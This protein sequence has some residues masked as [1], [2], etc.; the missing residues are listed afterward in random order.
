MPAPADGAASTEAKVVVPAVVGQSAPSTGGRGF[1]VDKHGFLGSGHF[2]EVYRGRNALT[3]EPVAIKLEHR[4]RTIAYREWEV[5]MRMQRQGCPAVYYT[6]H[7]GR[8][9]VCVMQLLGLTLQRALESRPTRRFTWPQVSLIGL[10]CLALL[11]RLH[12]HGYIH[13]DVK[14]ENFLL[15]HRPAKSTSSVTHSSA[16]AAA[17]GNDEVVV[18]ESPLAPMAVGEAAPMAGGDYLDGALVGQELQPAPP[19]RPS[20]S[21]SA[22]STP[23]RIDLNVPLYM[24]DMGL[25]SRWR[26][27]DE[28][29]R[30]IPYGQRIDH[31]S[32]T[33]RYASLNAHLGRFLTRRDDL[34]SLGY[35]LIYLLRGQLPWQG[36]MGDDKN[37]QVCEC[38]G[39]LL[40]S[41][42]CR[43]V[44]DE[45]RYFLAYVRQLS[46]AE[47][48]DYEYM[49]RVLDHKQ[50]ISW[51][52]THLRLAAEGV[53]L[54]PPYRQ[55]Q[56]ITR[57]A[58]GVEG[59]DESERIPPASSLTVTRTVDD[60]VDVNSASIS[61]TT[62]KRKGV[63]DAHAPANKRL[64]PGAA[65]ESVPTAL[66]Q[67]PPKILYPANR[68]SPLGG[69]LPEDALTVAT[70]GAPPR[71]GRF[72]IIPFKQ[73]KTHQWMI[74]ST[75]ANTSASSAPV[76]QVYT[77]HTSYK[78]LVREV[79]KKWAQGMRI[80]L[81]C[82]DGGMWTGVLNA[83]DPTLMEQA[84]HYCPGHEVPRDWIRNK[85]DEGFYIT[86]CSANQS[87]WGVVAS[88]MHRSRRY[89]QQSYI[90]S[91][92]F[93]SKW[94]ADKWAS[95]YAITSLCVQ[96]PPSAEQWLVV[97][98]RGS[99]YKEQVV[100]LDFGYP[101]ES[102]HAR[103]D[104]G[105]MVTSMACGADMSA[106]V[107]SRG[108]TVG[109][110][111]RC[112]RTSH[113]PLHK[114]RDDWRD[115]LYITATAFGRVS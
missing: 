30:H 18:V 19:T 86:A 98:S 44:P 40:V 63:G 51:V 102:I 31:F 33:V 106:Y 75:S 103:W 2:G 36:F 111:Q 45:L 72:E 97:M 76:S 59:S 49:A 79:E 37:M 107:M 85:W 62:G 84:M 6:G 23:Q 74:V 8:Y 43:A 7:V 112:T 55:Q 3:D 113:G 38:K 73:F 104:E 88:T 48:P 34:E 60:A 46:Y 105:Y 109:E 10:K 27:D 64:R 32:G 24:I 54:V 114:I 93:P 92:T 57:L 52:H 39:R 21:P 28:T 26:E 100:E 80:G 50:G 108:H 41:D 16:M 83:K 70:H 95:G 14:P 110:E 9:Y 11:K 81:L 47:Q 78:N 87:S 90:V 68:K 1:V 20:P 12:D 82:F 56:E 13:G 77:S 89:K 115:G 67:R 66:D 25:A 99:S 69:A 29:G 65:D 4:S 61:A 71:D 94:C 15:E 42:I 35:M 22:S 96:G 58:A 91:S 101:S 17:T 5:L 53:P